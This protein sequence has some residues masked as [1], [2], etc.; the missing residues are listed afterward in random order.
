MGLNCEPVVRNKKTM[1]LSK[2]QHRCP[3]HEI[4]IRHRE[5][6][7]FADG[8]TEVVVATD[9]TGMGMNLPIRRIVFLQTIKFDGVDGPQEHQKEKRKQISSSHSLDEKTVGLLYHKSYY[10]NKCRIPLI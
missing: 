8:D 5:A 3:W 4:I 9:A 1:V 6:R 2:A 10:H 7:K